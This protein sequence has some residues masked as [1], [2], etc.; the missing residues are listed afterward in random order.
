LKAKLRD[1]TIADYVRIVALNIRE[2]D[3]TLVER[4]EL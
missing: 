3:D 4:I 2:D 1:S